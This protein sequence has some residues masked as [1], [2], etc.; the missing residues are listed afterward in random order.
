VFLNITARQGEAVARTG[1]GHGSYEKYGGGE[2]E[3]TRTVLS[4]GVTELKVTPTCLLNYYWKN[5][6]VCG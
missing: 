6:M 4:Y 2:K 5:L 3:T 1:G